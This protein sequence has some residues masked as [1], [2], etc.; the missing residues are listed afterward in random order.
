[1][2]LKLESATSNHCQNVNFPMP[3][4]SL[5][6]MPLK[7]ILSRTTMKITTEQSEQYILPRVHGGAEPKTY[8]HGQV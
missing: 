7:H 3:T 5:P 1:M 6:V 4:Q 8:M 2:D